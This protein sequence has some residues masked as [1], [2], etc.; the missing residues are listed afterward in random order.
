M[1]FVRQTAIP[2]SNSTAQNFTDRTI[3]SLLSL[4]SRGSFLQKL[5]V[6]LVAIGSTQSISRGSATAGE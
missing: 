6:T 3:W 2:A 1:I 5:T 4:L